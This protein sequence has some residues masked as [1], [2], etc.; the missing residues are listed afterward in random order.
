MTE[1]YIPPVAKVLE[2]NGGDERV[3]LLENGAITTQHC[4]LDE[5]ENEIWLNEYDEDG[6]PIRLNEAAPEE[7][8]DA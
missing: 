5:N 2:D 3:V 6:Y 7:E 8:E 4:L 1:M